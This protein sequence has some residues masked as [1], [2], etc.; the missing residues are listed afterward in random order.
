VAAGTAYTC[1]EIFGD[2]V[3]KCKVEYMRAESVDAAG[4]ACIDENV[5][6]GLFDSSRQTDWKATTGVRL[7]SGELVRMT[8]LWL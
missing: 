8:T 2:T 3:R 4:I 1:T 7:C 5:R 6:M